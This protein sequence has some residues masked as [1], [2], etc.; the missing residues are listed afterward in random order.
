[1]TDADLL[2]ASGLNAAA[3]WQRA[4]EGS[5]HSARR[6]AGLAFDGKVRTRVASTGRLNEM[7]GPGWL[8]V[9]DA[10]YAFGPLSG[11]GVYRAMH[12]G[13]SAARELDESP[14]W[15][16]LVLQGYPAEREAEFARNLVLRA[17]SYG[18]ERRWPEAPFWSRRQASQG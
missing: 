16:D 2:Q 8:A 4:L 15:A 14:S 5:E 10:A 7:L 3:Y 17:H 18:M 1:M 6:M 11:T 9:G 12:M 13:L